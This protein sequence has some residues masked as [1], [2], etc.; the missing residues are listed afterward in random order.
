MMAQI[1][2]LPFGRISAHLLDTRQ[3]DDQIFDVN[4]GA[5]WASIRFLDYSPRAEIL[6]EK[7]KFSERQAVD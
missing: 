7:W 5:I 6:S 4:P 1:P 3:T 2:L